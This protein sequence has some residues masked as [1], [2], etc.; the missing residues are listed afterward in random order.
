MYKI[1]LYLQVSRVSM[2][3]LITRWLSNQL[4]LISNIWLK[5]FQ[6]ESKLEI[7]IQGSWQGYDIFT[8][9]STYRA[10]DSILTLIDN[11]F[12]SSTC[13]TNTAAVLRLHKI[14]RSPI[15]RSKQ[16][17]LNLMNFCRTGEF[18]RRVWYSTNCWR[19]MVRQD[20][21]NRA[22]KHPDRNGTE[23]AAKGIH[24]HLGLLSRVPLWT[25]PGRAQEHHHHLRCG[26]RDR[27]LLRFQPGVRSSRWVS[28][29]C[30]ARE[31]RLSIDLHH[32]FQ[33]FS[34][35]KEFRGKMIKIIKQQKKKNV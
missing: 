8:M 28:L 1:I 6:D 12:V 4:H 24:R 13:T 3:Q 31:Y 19:R 29:L 35:L 30:H 22:P 2:N 14:H 7:E 27:W 17:R 18:D 10:M 21:A 34:S 26:L 20:P 11:I 5:I 9:F 16:Q 15:S 25:A 23:G 33:D 32:A